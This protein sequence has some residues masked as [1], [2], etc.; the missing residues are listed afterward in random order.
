M[1]CFKVL[2]YFPGF[3]ISFIDINE[4]ARHLLSTYLLT[5]FFEHNVGN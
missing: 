5:Y 4:C 1:Y 2:H 3:Q